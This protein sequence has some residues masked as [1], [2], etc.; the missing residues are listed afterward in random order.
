MENLLCMSTFCVG[1]LRTHSRTVMGISSVIYVWRQDVCT[2]C[3]HVFCCA[4]GDRL[5]RVTP[6]AEQLSA[7]KKSPTRAPAEGRW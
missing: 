4:Q 3:S 5:L 7:T 2:Y 1:R 6:G